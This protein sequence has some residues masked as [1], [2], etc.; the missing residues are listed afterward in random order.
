MY[1]RIHGN[2]SFLLL[3]RLSRSP[4]N[5][6]TAFAQTVPQPASYAH[7]WTKLPA[8]CLLYMEESFSVLDMS[9]K[10]YHVSTIPL[11]HEKNCLLVCS[12]IF[13]AI[14]VESRVHT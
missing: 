2:L 9:Y 8:K 3:R 14:N 7:K 5:S 6:L 4:A 13:I 1:K 11:L 12:Y 10:K